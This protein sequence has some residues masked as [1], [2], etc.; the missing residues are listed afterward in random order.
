MK[1]DTG[2]EVLGVP[3]VQTTRGERIENVHSGHIA[4]VSIEDQGSDPMGGSG[5]IIAQAGDAS[6]LNYMRSTAK[7]IQALAAVMG[8]VLEDYGLGE[9]ALAIMCGSQQGEAEH[10]ALLTRMLEQTGIQ[11]EQLAFGPTLPASLRAR[12]ALAAA[13]G[14]PRK[15][16]H[17]CAGKHIGM[18][19]LC[20]KRGWPLDS[21]AQPE[22]P[23]QQELLGHVAAFADMPQEAI[24][25]AIDGCGLPVFALPLWRL[26]LIYG[27]L[28][29][30]AVAG[31]SAAMAAA[32]R[33]A[34]AMNSR[35][36]LVEGSGRLASV[37]L[38]DANVVAKSGAQGVF[39]F[40]LRREKLAVAMK[41]ADGGESAWPEAACAVLEQLRVGGN[42]VSRIR[43]Q[44][45]PAIV[46]D[47]GE[48]V[49]RRE[50][51]LQLTF[52]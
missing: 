14:G 48:I 31:G 36:A 11:E 43:E 2:I 23:L 8:G 41:L 47:A 16:Y 50:P 46:N 40:A 21:Y 6:I 9:D 33:I 38:G 44:F 4:V 35:P 29:A 22:H 7:P 32:A 51:C 17:V 20:K 52:H 5:K 37:M 15:L 12:D 30:P 45:P 34:A 24:G 13:G 18:L 42:L 49:G 1:K 26:A 19:A 25:R 27:R 3:L 10:I 39:A 28:A